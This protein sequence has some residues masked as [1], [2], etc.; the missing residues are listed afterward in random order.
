MPT[1]RPDYWYGTALYF[2]GTPG[3]GEI[4]RGPTADWAYDHENNTNV[5]HA[6]F[7]AAHAVAAM[8]TKAD[9]N[10]LNHDQYV[11]ENETA[12]HLGQSLSADQVTRFDFHSK[13]TAG[14]AANII[15]YAE[16]NGA[17]D[18]N[19]TAAG[20]IRFYLGAQL[21]LTLLNAGGLLGCWD[22]TPT[23]GQVAKGV[24]SDWAYDHVNTAAAHHTKYLDAEA[25][26]AMGAKGDANPLH[27]DKYTDAE[28]ELACEAIVDDT[29]VDGATDQPVSS[30]WAF[31]H[32]ADSGL[33][34]AGFSDRGDPASADYDE[35]DLT[36]DGSWYDL[37][38]SG[39]V[40]AG[41]TVVLLQVRVNSA[42]AGSWM[43]F[44]KNGNSNTSAVQAVKI[45][46]SNGYNHG[47]LLVA[48]DSSR[49]IEYWAHSTMATVLLTVTGWFS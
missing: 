40:P 32:A 38:L 31:D 27:H 42:T 29:P 49:V 15:R 5:H 17:W 24:T 9:N 33:H 7:Q 10:P 1:G 36:L 4:T 3:D 14:A 30:N 34:G 13:A 26:S 28:A 39:I 44:R 2:T 11:P 6:D 46:A 25:V 8:G 45:N 16:A 23:D 12:I 21:R 20:I 48:C 19:Q 47:C 18:F 22:D 43:Q 41:T 37:D 35:N